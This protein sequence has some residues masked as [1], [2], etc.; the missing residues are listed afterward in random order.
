MRSAG[1][2]EPTFA[3]LNS[4]ARS[5]TPDLNRPAPQTKGFDASGSGGSV[6]IAP[7]ETATLALRPGHRG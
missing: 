1:E 7:I 6:R 5:L 4:G 3:P 2:R